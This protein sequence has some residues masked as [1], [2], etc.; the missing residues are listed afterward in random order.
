MCTHCSNAE[1]RM[2]STSKTIADKRTGQIEGNRVLSLCRAYKGKSTNN[3]ISYVA[4]PAYERCS[5]V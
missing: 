5:K 1:H 4:L 3:V 2:S